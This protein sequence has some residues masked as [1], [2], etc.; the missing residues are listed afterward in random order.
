MNLI[1]RAASQT[2]FTLADAV[3]LLAR[4]VAPRRKL[5]L[6][7]HRMYA[8]GRPKGHRDA[9]L[10]QPGYLFLE[11]GGW[12]LEVAWRTCGEMEGAVRAA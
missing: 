10:M 7:P 11:L 8:A 5:D 6:F 4:I 9:Y 1:E 3:V 2:V 12:T